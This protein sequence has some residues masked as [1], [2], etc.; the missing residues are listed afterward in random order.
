MKHQYESHPPEVASAE[1]LTN[2]TYCSF[3]GTSVSGEVNTIAPLAEHLNQRYRLER[4]LGIGGMSAVY[5]A[6]D[7][8][9]GQFGDPQ[10][11]VA[12]KLMNDAYAQYPDANA[13]LYSEY[14]L[15]QRLHHPGIVRLYSFEI[16]VS[17][18]RA[19][20]SME[21]LPGTPLDQLISGHPDGL[22]WEALQPMAISALEAVAHV[23]A[24]DLVH[25][26]LKPANF[27]EQAQGVRLF[28]FG[29][30]E[31]TAVHPSALPRLQRKRIDAWTPSYAALELLEGDPLT[32][33]TD[34]YA[35]ACVLHELASGRHPYHGCNAK[36]A[37]A[38]RLERH[39]TCPANLPLRSWRALQRALSL[40]P[41]RRSINAQEL[42]AAF[43]FD[44]QRH[45]KRW[46][47]P[48]R[49]PPRYSG[50]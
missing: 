41:Y 43:Q 40:S 1:K 38:R 48:W 39:L 9:R 27:I 7:A 22:P 49:K 34:V 14:S 26:D 5:C 11:Y 8:L 13:L 10:P 36:Q 42:L 20:I 50:R 33:A 16:D 37:H 29:L 2:S 47:H 23:H 46:I 19:F 45:W 31:S 32:D 18:E 44:Q 4:L 6:H 17:T 3:A 15:T 21:W 25:G 30:S 24:H 28:D 35:L 12:I